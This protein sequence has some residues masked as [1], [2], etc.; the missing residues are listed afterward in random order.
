MIAL[1]A[2][3]SLFSLNALPEHKNFFPFNKMCLIAS[4]F[5]HTF[6]FGVVITGSGIHGFSTIGLAG[7]QV[8]EHPVLTGEE[9]LEKCFSGPW[10]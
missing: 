6:C 1:E 4:L 8:S 5:L 10:V 7:Q 2:G 9:V 3:S